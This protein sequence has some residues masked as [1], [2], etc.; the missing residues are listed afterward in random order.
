MLFLSYATVSKQQG[1]SQSR[2]LYQLH[3][4]MLVQQPLKPMLA[5]ADGAA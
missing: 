3:K 5:A 1:R 2:L 4:E